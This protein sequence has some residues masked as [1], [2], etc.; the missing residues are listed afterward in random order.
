MAK[1]KEQ[2][3]TFDAEKTLR[4]LI[5]QAELRRTY[6]YQKLDEELGLAKPL[7]K[8][9]KD[10]DSLILESI[11]AIGSLR[12]EAQHGYSYKHG[13]SVI[14]DNKSLEENPNDRP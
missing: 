12:R 13:L 5:Q 3:T 9:I 14:P 10:C 4:D 1:T 8:G 2:Q 7:L 11:Y 6:L